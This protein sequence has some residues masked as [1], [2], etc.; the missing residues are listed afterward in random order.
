MTQVILLRT[1]D[2][3]PFLLP[4]VTADLV[5]PHLTGEI[6][7]G[8]E[9]GESG[10]GEVLDDHDPVDLFLLQATI[11]IGGKGGA[12]VLNGLG[13]A[14]FLEVKEVAPVEGRPLGAGLGTDHPHLNGGVEAVEHAVH[15]GR[16]GGTTRSPQVIHGEGGGHE[17]T[18][19][20]RVRCA[21]SIGR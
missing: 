21:H 12:V 20:G 8:G 7:A 9:R 5:G 16:C 19:F 3:A 17:L 1:A 10:G 6:L 14:V 18:E 4:P 11:G 15:G 13:V 2:I